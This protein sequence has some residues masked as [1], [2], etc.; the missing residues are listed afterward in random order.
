ME[1]LAPKGELG[2]TAPMPMPGLVSAQGLSTSARPRPEPQDPFFTPPATPTSP[3]ML[4][5]INVKPVAS[6]ES[7][8]RRAFAPADSRHRQHRPSG[9][10]LHGS[11]SSVEFDI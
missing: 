9:A 11:S 10:N 8:A 2:G 6:T 3:S 7:A 5:R 4:G 1:E